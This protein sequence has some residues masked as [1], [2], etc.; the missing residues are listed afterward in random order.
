M[1]TNEDIEGFNITHVPTAELWSMSSS[2]KH[3][4]PP[5]STTAQTAIVTD[6]RRKLYDIRICAVDGEFSIDI[7][8]LCTLYT[9]DQLPE[10][11]FSKLEPDSSKLYDTSVIEQYQQLLD[12]GCPIAAGRL[13]FGS[14]QVPTR[15]S[16]DELCGQSVF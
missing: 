2:N 12:D 8:N 3:I 6:A 13:F 11:F 5:P 7:A 14:G 10:R 9:L 16:F 15:P 4:I 1:Y